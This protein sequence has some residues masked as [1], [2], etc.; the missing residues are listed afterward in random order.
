[1][2]GL[3]G[4]NADL[5]ADGTYTGVG[6]DHKHDPEAAPGTCQRDDPG[7]FEGRTIRQVAI[8]CSRPTT[9]IVVAATIGTGTSGQTKRSDSA[10]LR[11]VAFIVA[12]R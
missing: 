5:E 9:R 8:N 6:I 3:A 12:I 1:M 2:R 11:S 10:F 4:K 7:K